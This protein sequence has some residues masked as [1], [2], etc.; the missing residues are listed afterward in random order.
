M[1]FRSLRVW[2]LSAALFGAASGCLSPTLPLPPPSEPTVS[3]VREGVV[4]FQG[5]VESESEVL[6]LDRNSNVIAGQYTHTG[7]YDFTLAA[8]DRDLI[9][10]W[11]IRG[12]DESP[13]KDFVLRVP[14]PT[15]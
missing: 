13:P 6:A 8:Q 1:K 12:T 2:L 14:A 7:D 9:S 3:A 4:R 10:L 5:N 11:Y 15:P